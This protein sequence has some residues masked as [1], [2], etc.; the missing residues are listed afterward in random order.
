ML[1][2]TGEDR[3]LSNHDV[4]GLVWSLSSGKDQDC[5]EVR[6]GEVCESEGLLLNPGVGPLKY[7]PGRFDC[8]RHRWIGLDDGSGIE[9]CVRCGAR[10][11]VQA[12]AERAVPRPSEVV[13]YLSPRRAS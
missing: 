1:L 4:P 5:H 13:K 11:V 12:T 3:H 7:E 2:G 9:R 8:R 10:R 6:A